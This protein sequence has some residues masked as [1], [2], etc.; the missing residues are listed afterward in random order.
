MPSG[1]GR[2][3]RAS[4]PWGRGACLGLRVRRSGTGH[5]WSRY[6]PTLATLLALLSLAAGVPVDDDA[7]PDSSETAPSG[8]VGAGHSPP[9][10]RGA[11]DGG[12]ASAPK[13]TY[14][15]AT[16]E[17]LNARYANGQPSNSYSEAGVLMHQFDDTG[18]DPHHGHLVSYTRDKTRLDAT[19]RELVLRLTYTAPPR[20]GHELSKYGDRFSAS[21]VSADTPFMF[22]SL[23][24]GLIVHP[25]VAQAAELCSWAA[26]G[27]TWFT[28]RTCFLKDKLWPQAK[29][30]PGGEAIRP[31][32]GFERREG[33]VPGCYK[34]VPNAAEE[35]AIRSMVAWKDRWQHSFWTK[36]MEAVRAT[37]SPPPYALPLRNPH[38]HLCRPDPHAATPSADIILHRRDGAQGLLHKD[39]SWRGAVPMGTRQSRAHA[40][41][42]TPQQAPEILQPAPRLVHVQ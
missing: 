38:S 24:A 13:W 42:A 32:F 12:V 10:S 18:F 14:R 27:L 29:R 26:D 1:V 31:V 8:E 7:V 19:E 33:C 41:A 39:P 34:R 4:A 36:P 20:E 23:A 15:A 28:Y 17:E 16:A 11:D 2:G 30:T 6:T 35:G 9:D 3:P 40:E 25:D 5:H 22:S 21:L 37:Q